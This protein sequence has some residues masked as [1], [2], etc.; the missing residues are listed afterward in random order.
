MPS[1]KLFACFRECP[2]LYGVIAEV[3]FLPIKPIIFV[4]LFL[5]RIS[6]CPHAA[7]I[8]P[9][10]LTMYYQENDDTYYTTCGTLA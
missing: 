2:F 7:A 8:S 3:P 5:V 10:W 6:S 4:S 9:V 1:N